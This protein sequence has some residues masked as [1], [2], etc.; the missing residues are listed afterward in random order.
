[1]DMINIQEHS[2]D[3]ENLIRYI[4]YCL[5]AKLGLR[6]TV[7][8]LMDETQQMSYSASAGL[9]KK[10]I[11]QNCRGIQAELKFFCAESRRLFLV[12]TLDAGCQFDLVGT[13]GGEIKCYDV[14]TAI[15]IKRHAN[16][17]VYYG[18]CKW[19]VLVADVKGQKVRFY[20]ST[21]TGLSTSPISSDTMKVDEKHFGKA[22][23]KLD[24]QSV[25]FFK[26]RHAMFSRYSSQ[27]MS[28]DKLVLEIRQCCPGDVGD[29]LCAHLYFYSTYKYALNLVPTL[30]Y[31]DAI[32][33]VGQHNGVLERYHIAVKGARITSADR[34]Y[35]T[36]YRYVDPARIVYCDVGNRM[37]SFEHCDSPTFLG[38]ESSLP[39]VTELN[40]R[41]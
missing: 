26:K 33:F 28:L 10:Q 1:M 7:E 40:D 13:K 2:R 39:N 20:E 34:Q 6:K 14:T 9:S 27:S 36:A 31:G 23:V 5:M 4:A 12:P 29:M 19:P 21:S 16:N 32:D 15:G 38:K 18:D 37:F 30:S 17:R 22:E 3:H 41:I 35:N 11:R 24:Q 8:W 25:D